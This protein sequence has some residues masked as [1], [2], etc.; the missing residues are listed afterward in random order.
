MA[1]ERCHDS[2]PNG[3]RPSLRTVKFETCDHPMQLAEKSVKIFMGTK[4]INDENMKLIQYD[5]INGCS[6]I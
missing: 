2:P 6:L 3:Q 4:S 5:S 1:K